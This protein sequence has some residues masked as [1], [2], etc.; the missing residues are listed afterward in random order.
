MSGYGSVNPSHAFF[1]TLETDVGLP[2][3][4]YNVNRIAN[5]GNNVYSFMP[6]LNL[7]WFPSPDWELST[8]AM[9]EFDSPNNATH[10]YNGAV[11]FVD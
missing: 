9:C 11:S 5:T 2:T 7:T 6:N 1:A 4:S 8:T 3:G 10:Y